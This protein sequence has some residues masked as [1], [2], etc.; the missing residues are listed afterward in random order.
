[1]AGAV[2]AGAYTA[3]VVDFLM[4]ALEQWQSRKEVLRAWLANPQGPAPELV[5]LHDVSIEIFSGASAGG[6]CAAIASVMV[7]QDFV[8]IHD[9]TETNTNNT[10]YEAWVNQIDIRKLLETDDIEP[11]VPLTALLDCKI[12]DQIA[13]S[14]LSPKTPVPRPYI[15]PALNLMLTL[16]NV[17]GT[18]YQLYEDPVNVEEFTEY[19]GDK[20]Q[21]ETTNGGAA[22]L[23]PRA[24][25][26]PAGDGSK[27]AWWLLQFAAKATGAVP[28]VLAPRILPRD[29]ADYADP[30]WTTPCTAPPTP[31]PPAFPPP[32]P[33]QILTL[34][35]DGGVTDNDPFDLAHDFLAGL[36]PKPPNCTN[37][38]APND[39]DRAVITIAPFPAENKFN[40]AYSPT[41][42]A[43]IWR[44]AGRLITVL[45]SQS[46]F[47]GENLRVL[48][49]GASF[50]QFAIAPSDHTRAALPALQCG[51]LGAF[52]GFF[53]RK[54]RVH[55]FLLGRRNCQQ[56][57]RKRFVLPTANPVIGGGLSA[58]G[59]LAGEIEKDFSV[60]AP[61]Q[62]TAAQGYTWLPLIP[63]TGTAKDDVPR[64]ARLQ[65]TKADLDAVLGL[66]IKRLE[67]IKGPLLTGA[68]VI[69]EALA[70]LALAWPFSKLIKGKLRDVIAQGLGSDLE[71]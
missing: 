33:R 56:F 32:P 15:S 55:D 2:S 11:G 27:G 49:P 39:A 65:M 48:A 10:F 60:P 68:P 22:P 67:A 47:L 28:L 69:I 24:K 37:P 66:I 25:P 51:S 29:T 18:P 38:R 36:D 64:P 5:P 12:I 20:L 46:R 14:A 52:G 44:M 4:E 23:N 61:T 26:L 42:E 54:F 6:M 53:D 41:E 35:V 17:R 16:T 62:A 43:G 70:G 8:H 45:L 40:P 30:P 1:M 3:G 31:I 7:Q 13:A 9:G 71:G 34:N 21:F 63:C 50:S 57:L 59:A 58:A 19:Y